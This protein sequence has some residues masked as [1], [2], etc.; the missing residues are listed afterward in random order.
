MKNIRFFILLF[1]CLLIFT[2]SHAQKNL[3]NEKLLIGIKESPPFVMKTDSGFSGISVELWGKIAENLGVDYEYR[4]YDL[5]QLL[6]AI[7][8]GEVDLSINPLTVTSN[9]LK[10]FY[11][12]QPYFISHLAIAVKVQEKNTIISFIKN[13]FSKEF[14]EVILM[15]FFTIFV[16]GLILWLIERKK[17]AS[18]FRKGFR[19]IGD[20]I[21]WSAVTM[22]TVGYG[23]KSPITTSGRIISII[24][25][26]TAVIII[27]SFTASISASLTYNKLQSNI[28]NINDLRKVEVGTIGNSGT[29][30]FLRYNK[31]NT[32]TFND[33]QVGLSALDN[34]IIKAFVYDEPIIAY[35][36]KSLGFSDEIELHPISANSVYFSFSSNDPEYIKILNPY[37]IEVIESK[38]WNKILKKYNLHLH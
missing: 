20:G 4:I 31:I 34:G 37:L 21:W 28:D 17:N 19:G 5:G 14:L 26:F 23:D 7:E 2:E 16:F 18:Q 36:V 24:W 29:A 25:M 1:V 27:S 13:V 8:N 32:K 22:T 15:L 33:V 3:K 12:S 30:D 6:Q 10:R 38:E 11:F 9:R 35:N